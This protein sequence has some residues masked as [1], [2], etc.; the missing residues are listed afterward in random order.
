MARILVT[1]ILAALLA[2]A[3]IGESQDQT[4]GQISGRVSRV[5]DGSPIAKAEIALDAQD[6]QTSQ[7]LGGGRIARSQS[8]GSLVFRDVPAGS[9]ALRAA[10]NGFVGNSTKLQF[11]SAGAVTVDLRLVAAGVVAGTVV[12]DD[13]DP[14]A[15]LDVSAIAVDFLPGDRRQLQLR[16]RATTD[17]QGNFRI[18]DLAPRSYFVRAGGPLNYPMQSVPFKQG[19]NGGT[20]YRDTYYPG[21]PL[22]TQAELIELASGAEQ[23]VRLAVGAENVYT[24]SGVVVNAAMDPQPEVQWDRPADS[25]QMW[26]DRCRVSIERDGRSRFLALPTGDYT[27]RAVAIDRQ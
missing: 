14:V 5:D 12:D 15:H 23:H 10:H 26:C 27:L 11:A 7:A 20:Q 8:D 13:G 9:Y 16:A 2:T 1:S 17:D 24:I 21:T 25:E 18:A 22:V 3:L 19:P 4:S 6:Q